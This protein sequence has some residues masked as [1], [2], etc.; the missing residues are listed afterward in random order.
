MKKFRIVSAL[1]AALI[2]VT[3]GF[4]CNITDKDSAK[5]EFYCPDG[6]PALAAAGLFED[7]T[8]GTTDI[9]MEYHVVSA[10]SITNYVMK[11]TQKADVAILPVNA[12]AKICGTGDTYVMTSVLTH[13]NLYIVSDKEI[14]LNDLVGQVVGVIGRGKVPDATLKSVLNKHGIAYEESV[15]AVEG[16]VALAYYESGETLMPAMKQ[17]KI[18][19]GLL[20]E[21]AATKIV[22]KLKTNYTYKLD[23]AALY[24]GSYPQAAMVVKK[25]VL[26]DHPKFMETLTAKLQE[27]IAWVNTASNAQ[28]AIDAVNARLD[29][30]VVASLDAFVTADVIS[31]CSIRYVSAADAKIGVNAYLTAI[32]QSAASDA[33]FYAA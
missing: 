1:F 8:L 29:D 9:E 12:A 21:P 11:S 28:A 19:I 16:K 13:G 10:E 4:G 33:F 24:G 2:A 18:K 23:L 31:R 25:S 20:P 15:E 32:G 6:A 5:L 22:T 7:K 3:V 17:N 27:S 30:G 26:T 14:S